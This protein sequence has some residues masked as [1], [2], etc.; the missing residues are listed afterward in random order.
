MSQATIIWLVVAVVMAIVEASTVQLVSIWFAIGAVAGCIT[1]IYTESLTI[2][3]I[4]FAVVSALALVITRPLVK[5]IKVK[6][7]E[8]TNSDR[9]IGKTGVVIETIDNTVPKGLVKVDNATWSARSVDGKPIVAGTSVTVAAIE[10][11]KLMVL[12]SPRGE[13]VTNG[14]G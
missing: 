8:A 9:Y 14:D 7:A 6:K 12:P 4:V 13:G 2:Q 10:G 3:L 1:S 5:R 11:V